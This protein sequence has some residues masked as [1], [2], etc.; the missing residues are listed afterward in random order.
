MS[1]ISSIP[2]IPSGIKSQYGI[3]I[4]RTIKAMQRRMKESDLVDKEYA[5]VYDT[6]S[7]EFNTFFEAYPAIFT[8]IIR[9]ESLNTIAATLYYKDKIARGLMTENQL[10]EQLANKFLPP[11]LKKEA[12]SR[13]KEMQ[14]SGKFD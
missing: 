10:S 2:A 14:E 7:N 11:D 8:K 4:V 6:L 3:Y 13:I 1:T 9:G 12:D 5:V